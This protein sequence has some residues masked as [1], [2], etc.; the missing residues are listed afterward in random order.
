LSR[1][2]A[3]AEA[4]SNAP[5]P[6]ADKPITARLAVSAPAADAIARIGPW[7]RAFA[8]HISMVGPGVITSSVTAAR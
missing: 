5:R 8:A 4:A 7:F 1:V 2:N 6:T 3:V